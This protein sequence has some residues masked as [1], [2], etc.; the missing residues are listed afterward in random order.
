MTAES[1]DGQSGKTLQVWSP[2]GKKDSQDRTH[3]ATL[4]LHFLPLDPWTPMKCLLST[5]ALQTL[6]QGLKPEC[7]PQ[8]MELIPRRA[9]SRSPTCARC[10]NHGV[11]LPT[12]RA[13]SACASSGM[14]VSQ[15]C[16]HPVS[17]R[18]REGRGWA[19]SKRWLT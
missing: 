6:P 8:G 15:M 1:R 12:S 7:T 4:T 17:M 3:V 9:V 2:R 11:S 19:S 10:R 18:S 13:T 14:R 16:P 5:T